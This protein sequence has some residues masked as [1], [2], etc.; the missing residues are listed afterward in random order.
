MMGKVRVESLE[1]RGKNGTFCEFLRLNTLLFY[2]AHTNR[3]HMNRLRQLLPFVVILVVVI[4]GGYG[5][6]SAG[7]AALS[8]IMSQKSQVAAAVIA[9]SSTIITGI[10]A[11]VIAQQRSKSREIAEAHRP[12]KIE[13]YN[14]FITTMI[15]IIRKHKGTDSKAIEGDKAIEEFFYTFTAEVVLWGSRGVLGHYATFRNLGQE[16]N[17]NIVLVMDDIMQAMRKDLGLSNWGYRAA[18]S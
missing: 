3:L 1:T 5:V 14:S 7:A 12:K 15:G 16:K 2:L 6:W 11:V 8:W 9:F 4:A 18:I 10:G 13:L 17:Q